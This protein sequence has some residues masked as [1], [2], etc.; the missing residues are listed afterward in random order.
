MLHGQTFGISVSS[1]HTPFCGLPFHSAYGILWC[2]KK[3]MKSSYL[4]F[5]YLPVLSALYPLAFSSG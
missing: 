5:L 3:M 2:T 4:Y 1:M